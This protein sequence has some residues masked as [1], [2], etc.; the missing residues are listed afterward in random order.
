MLLAACSSARAAAKVPFC[1]ASAPHL[2]TLPADLHHEQ[3]AHFAKGPQFCC[4]MDPDLFLS[5][6]ASKGWGI[7]FRESAD[8]TKA[9]SGMSDPPLLVGCIS[10]ELENVICKGG[11]P[12]IDRI[13]SENNEMPGACDGSSHQL[14]QVLPTALFQ[15]SPNPSTPAQDGTFLFRPKRDDH[16]HQHPRTEASSTQRRNRMMIEVMGLWVDVYVCVGGW[17]GGGEV[18]C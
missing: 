1:A 6:C 2:C 18:G 8:G 7:C 12:H 10:R 5:S 15:S 13:E 4:Q 11:M 16:Q 3:T 14:E 17:G 9:F